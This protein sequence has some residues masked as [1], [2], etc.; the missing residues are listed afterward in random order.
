MKKIF[1]FLMLLLIVIPLS[2][3]ASQEPPDR[4]QEALNIANKDLEDVAYPG[5]FQ[6][7]NKKG[8]TFNDNLYDTR[9][10]FVYGTPFKD[11]EGG[12]YRY[13]GYTME[14]DDKFTNV[15]YPND[16]WGGGYLE[17]RNWIPI[18]W[19][20]GF[21]QNEDTFGIESNYFDENEDYRKGINEFIHLGL[22]EYF[23]EGTD[24][25]PG[26]ACYR[27]NDSKYRF[28]W[29]KYVHILQPPTK[30]T[31][32]M[33]RMFHKTS[34]GDIWYI[35][36]PIRPLQTGG[37][38]NFAV[39]ITSNPVEVQPGKTVDVTGKLTSYSNKPVTTK[40]RWTVNGSTKYKGKVTFTKERD[41]NFSFTMPSN[42]T[43]VAVE[44]NPNHDMPKNESTF[45]DNKD[46]TTIDKIASSLPSNPH[47]VL[48][49]TSPAG[50]DIHGDYHPAEKRPQGTAKWG[51]T[52]KATLKPDKP[53]APRGHVTSWRITFAKIT[54][55]KRH[56]KF[57]F[58][59]PVQP[60]SNTTKT[61]TLQ[62]HQAVA[63][64]HENWSINGYASGT[65]AAGVY[66]WIQEKTVSQNPKE[67][68]VSAEYS[69]HFEYKY[70]I[71]HVDHDTWT[72][73]EGN[74]HSDTDVWYE[75]IRKDDS[76]SDTVNT[77]LLV[78]GAARVPLAH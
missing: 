29:Y 61:M 60:V 19:D 59:H 66:D 10:L 55:P 47:L 23:G 67:Y 36:V 51:D 25:Y 11:F 49:A 44:V 63:E 77:K 3:S 15:K 6:M 18:P 35:T 54:Y 24:K 75:T 78:N 38:Q 53:S 8:R 56:Q 45:S 28:E 70:E 41:L 20:V 72:D 71:R 14:T 21:L 46:S 73:S 31:W 64:F 32:G 1:L 26:P 58:G 30:W 16:S 13:L 12:N 62:G 52:V 40:V 4:Y 34:D 42:D 17:D 57:T 5:Y 50:K 7:Q 33:G 43:T 69:I 48:Q 9:T 76:Y 65:G 2:A 74:T 27:G 68:P 37:S 39:N 22:V